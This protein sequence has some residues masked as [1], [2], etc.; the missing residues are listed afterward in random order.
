MSQILCFGDSIA[1][2]A[3]DIAGGWVARLR[4][5]YDSRPDAQTNFVEVFN[6][7]VTGN[8]SKDLAERI[9]FEITHRTEPD[10][11]NICIIAIGI[12]DA[13]YRT[14][15]SRNVV[16]I[17]DFE[18]NLKK[19]L[20]IATSHCPSVYILG[21]AP[22]VESKVT[23]CPWFPAIS[24]FEKDIVA[25]N[26]A[27]VRVSH[28]LEIPFISAMHVPLSQL[29]DGIH[30]DEHGHELIARTVYGAISK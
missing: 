9:E 26:Q 7:G 10:P 2:G 13:A 15:K 18:A 28:E 3:F 6:L 21:L 12:N 8:T 19:I 23:P 16:S 25:Y 27:L 30:P 17:A 5:I 20:A 24:Y 1:Y 11:E 14:A 29:P 4:R 22:I